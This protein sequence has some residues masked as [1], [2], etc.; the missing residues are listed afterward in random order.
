MTGTNRCRRHLPENLRLKDRLSTFSTLL[1]ASCE[2]FERMALILSG[3]HL[4][5][6]PEAL[7]SSVIQ[8]LPL[9]AVYLLA[10]SIRATL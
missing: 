5:T 9:P 6:V 7:L 1:R 8:S 2:Q 10:N 4:S 3:F